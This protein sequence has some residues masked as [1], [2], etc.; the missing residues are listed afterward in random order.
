MLEV[1]EVDFTPVVQET[2]IAVVRAFLRVDRADEFRPVFQ[3]GGLVDL[4]VGVV[5]P[6]HVLGV[7]EVVEVTL[8]GVVER[9][10]AV[11]GEDLIMSGEINK[12]TCITGH[13]LVMV[14]QILRFWG[15]IE[16]NASISQSIL[17]FKYAST[18]DVL[19]YLNHLCG[20]AHLHSCLL[21]FRYSWLVPFNFSKEKYA[22]E[23]TE[24]LSPPLF[25]MF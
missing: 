10:P 15:I 7:G 8:V 16:Q 1:A 13:L 23:S 17:L 21:T 14:W 18:I 6:G 25:D 2:E 12:I 9:L 11:V 20:K 22:P 19:H 24:L 5:G 3:W 4:V